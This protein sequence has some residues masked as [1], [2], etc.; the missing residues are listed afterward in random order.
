MVRRATGS[1]TTLEQFMF[2]KSMPTSRRLY[3]KEMGV[4]LRVVKGRFMQQRHG[5]KSVPWQKSD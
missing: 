5:Y 4:G 2:L 1:A 3:L